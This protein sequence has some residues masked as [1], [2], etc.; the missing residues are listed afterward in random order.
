MSNLNGVLLVDK[1]KDFTSFDV[2]G[3]LRPILKT[4]KIGHSGTLDPM[5]TGVL[6]LFIGNATGAIDF[7]TDNSKAYIATIKFGIATDTYD[8]TGNIVDQKLCNLSIDSITEVIKLYIGEID[9]IPPIYSAIKVNGQKLYNIARKGKIV[10]IKS[11]KVFIDNIKILNFDEKKCEL[12]IHVDCQ[13]G[14][15][16]RSLAHDIGISLNTCACLSYLRRVKSNDFLIDNCYT[17]EEITHFMQSDD[18]FNK[19][20]NVEDL[21]HNYKSIFLDKKQTKLFNN[22]V[23]LHVYYIDNIDLSNCCD[24]YYKVY[25]FEKNFLALSYIDDQNYMRVK[26][27][28]KVKTYVD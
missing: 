2:I 19:V 15:Y 21:F 25:D 16:I 24:E 17:I 11:R 13:K 7:L 6:P 3:K 12:T 27:F 22:G 26:K 18:I 8:I 14:T 10:D 9:Q 5:A 28:F 1:P 23:K 20:I 4:K